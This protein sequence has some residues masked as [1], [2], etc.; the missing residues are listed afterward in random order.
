MLLPQFA[1]LGVS[2]GFDILFFLRVLCLKLLLQSLY[3][4]AIVLPSTTELRIC[5]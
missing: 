3:K 4:G 1:H 2:F 5:R